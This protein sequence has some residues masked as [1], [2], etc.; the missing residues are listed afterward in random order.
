LP[1]ETLRDKFSNLS[2]KNLS[3]SLEKPVAEIK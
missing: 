2:P 3:D 1:L